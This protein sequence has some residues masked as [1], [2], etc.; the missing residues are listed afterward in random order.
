MDREKV[1]ILFASKTLVMCSRPTVV[2][3]A[4]RVI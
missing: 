4:C 3:L 2:R 1:C